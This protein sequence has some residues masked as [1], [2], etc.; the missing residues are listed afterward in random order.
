MAVHRICMERTTHARRAQQCQ[1]RLPHRLLTGCFHYV[2]LDETV[3]L[4]SSIGVALFLANDIFLQLSTAV[5]DCTQHGNKAA[6]CHAG[7]CVIM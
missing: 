3:K 7:F 1:L 6:G 5:L 2:Q 4:A